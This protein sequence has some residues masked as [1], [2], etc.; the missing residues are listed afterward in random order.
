MLELSDIQSSQQEL[1]DYYAQLAAQH[2]TPAWIGGGISIEPRSEAV[3]YLWHWRDLR[4]QAMRAAELVGTQQAER[5]VLRLTNPKLPGAASTTLVANIQIVMPGEIAQAHR[6]SAAALRL[7]IEG[8]GGYTVVNGERVPMYPGDL[9]LTPNW[10]W[11]DH[12]NDTD[13][14]MI[15]LDGLDTPLV[16]MLEAGF[17]EEHHQERQDFGAA[18][19]TSQ[20]HYPMSEMRAALQLLAAADTPDIGAEIILEY[21]NR[22]TGGPVMPTIACHMQLLRPGEQTPARRRVCRTNYHV[23][24]G[25]GYSV[26]G[27]QL[28]NWE[29]KDVFTVPTWTFCEHV[30]TADRPAFLFSF[31]DAPVMRALSLYRDEIRPS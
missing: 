25:A 31:S 15:W 19:N 28:L 1:Q 4:P 27:G 2:V 11:H 9:V 8:R 5:R 14:P 12:A 16:R 20:W 30:N 18:V 13:A 17:Y 10:S 23:V 29:D 3:A 6:H 24:E 21:K 26:V 7:I 22:V